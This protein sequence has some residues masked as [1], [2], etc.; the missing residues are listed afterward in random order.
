M[1]MRTLLAT[2][3]AALM[4]TGASAQDLAP[5]NSDAEPDRMDWSQLEAEFGPFPEVPEGT[6]VGGV[7]KTL[8]NEYWR[9]LGEG[10]TAF[11][12]Q[13]GVEVVYQAAQNEGDQL[14]QLSIAE[15][16]ITQGYGESQLKILTTEAEAANRRAVVRNITGL[17]Q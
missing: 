13:Y 2:A 14:G 16:L 8:T 9:S 3:A 17:L 7:S 5:L 11:A 1:T 6:R 15:N 12:D 10:Y 4:I